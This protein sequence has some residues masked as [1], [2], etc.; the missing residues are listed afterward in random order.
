MKIL[1]QLGYIACASVLCINTTYASSTFNANST[2]SI[3]IDSITNTTN[4]G[5]FSDLE[6]YGL[7]EISDSS[8]SPGFGQVATGDG[9]SSYNHTGDEIDSS[10][11]SVAAGDSI[12]QSFSSTGNASNG[13]VDAYYQAL[14]NIDFINNG[15]DEFIIKYSLNY[16]LNAA[17]SG[18]FATNTVAIEYFNDLGDIDGYEEASSSTL[19]NT[20]EQ[21]L[22]LASFTLNLAAFEA[23]TFYADVSINGFAQ[24]TAAPVPLPAAGWLLL[25]GLGL[26]ARYKKR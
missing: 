15:T 16:D 2:I 22:S 21:N 1:N 20:S 8:F 9:N 26:L 25:S 11:A 13:S 3:S 23:D 14:G 4:A 12:S 17:V 7:F 10:A 6:I 19:V 18:E 24:A 5:V